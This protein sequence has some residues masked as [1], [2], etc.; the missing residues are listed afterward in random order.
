MR[1]TKHFPLTDATRSA[2][3]E[4]LGINNSPADG[5]MDNLKVSAL[6]MEMV[7]RLLGNNPITPSSWYRSP[8]L[9]EEVG[10][11]PTSHHLSGLA[12]DFNVWQFGSV[13]K[14]FEAIKNSAIP[15]DQLIIEKVGGKEWIHISFAPELRREAFGIS[16]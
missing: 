8:M 16:D 5:I 11:K 12:V 14:Q 6:G 9:N 1:L 2:T 4:R 10:G 7:R 3:A 15:Y 13:D